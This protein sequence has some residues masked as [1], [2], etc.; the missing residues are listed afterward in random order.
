MPRLSRC[1]PSKTRSC[2]HHRTPARLKQARLLTLHTRALRQ[3]EPHTTAV[4]ERRQFFPLRLWLP[5]SR[6]R[7]GRLRFLQLFRAFIAAHLNG[8]TA[9]FHFDRICVQLAVAS[10]TGFL[11]HG[12]LQTRS[13]R[14]TSG[15]RRS[16]EPLSRY[17]AICRRG[18]ATKCRMT[19]FRWRAA[20]SRAE[21]GAEVAVT[22]E[23]KVQ[24]ERG[25]VIVLGKK[26]QGT[27]QP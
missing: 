21:H 15:P 24:G 20:V 9:E 3:A 17:L 18:L 25:K 1:A 2:L 12:C 23:T 11:S 4:P 16:G 8:P 10:R 19:K 6:C 26:V 22:G 5:L 14:A 7:N 27:R 13:S